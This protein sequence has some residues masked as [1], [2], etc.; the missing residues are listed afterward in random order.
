MVYVGMRGVC[1]QSLHAHNP[2]KDGWEGLGV[3]CYVGVLCERTDGVRK[4]TYTQFTFTQ[5]GQRTLGRREAG[6][7]E[8][9]V[10]LGSFASARMALEI[11]PACCC[12]R[13]ACFSS[14]TSEMSPAANT[15]STPLTRKSGPT[16]WAKR[17]TGKCEAQGVRWGQAKRK[18]RMVFGRWELIDWFR[19]QNVYPGPR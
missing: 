1:T 15:F 18:K 19:L 11:T 17:Q 16:W 2:D 7:G 8:S 13:K 5:Y 9:A 3:C 10:T 6:G 4:L 14:F 12:A